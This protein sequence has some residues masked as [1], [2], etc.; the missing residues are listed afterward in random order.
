MGSYDSSKANT[1]SLRH[2]F[3]ANKIEPAYDIVCSSINLDTK[4]EAC[5]QTLKNVFWKNQKGQMVL[6]RACY[7]KKYK[8]IKMKTRG[9]VEKLRKLEIMETEFRKK[10]YCDFYHEHNKTTAAIRLLSPKEFHRRT[11]QENCLNLHFNY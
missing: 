8:D 4:C 1:N 5:E 11:H 9:V 7:N 6:C 3:G 2:S 10:R